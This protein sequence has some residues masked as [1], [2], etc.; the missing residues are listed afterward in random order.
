MGKRLF[1]LTLSALPFALSLVGAMLLALCVSADAQGPRKV[2]R[3]GYLDPS[4]RAASADRL[5][6]FR[7]EMSK[8]GWI[9]GKNLGME[10]RF[11]EQQPKR[12]PKLAAE[13]VR[14][15]VDVIFCSST[16]PVLA[17]KKATTTIPIVM[18]SSGDPVEAGLV[19]SLARPGGNV[20]G[21]AS[22]GPELAG[23]RLEL[24]K[25]AAPAVS[26]VGF[27]WFSAG[28]GIGARLQLKEVRSAA[29]ALDIKLEEIETKILP[30]D[31]EGAFRK[32]VEKHVNA[33][34]T[35]SQRVLSG[36]RNRIVELAGKFRLPAI[37]PEEEFVENG[38]LMY[39]GTDRVDAYRRVSVYVDKILRGAKPADLPVEQPTKFELVINLKAAK[40]IG[41][42]IPPNVLARADRVI[43]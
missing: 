7:Q 22:F 29:L 28:P 20:T 30:D 40:Q 34:I 5:E 43:R 16:P 36:E 8:L 15:K 42:T 10:Y 12:L 21:L 23:K 38:G 11:A 39:Y 37:Y 1:G 35:A 6:A 9:E 32:A 31:L 26:R 4:T 27:L 17:A 2:L 3:I 24:L 18:A 33:M 25:E 41:L 13:L 19:A 14:L